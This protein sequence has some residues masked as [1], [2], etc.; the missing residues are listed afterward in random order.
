[1]AYVI[2]GREVYLL[3]AL[4]AH[5]EARRMAGEH[6]GPVFVIGAT[7]DEDNKP[8]PVVNVF[9]RVVLNRTLDQWAKGE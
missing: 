4:Q 9:E 2:V 5:V 7:L 8:V 6:D 3:G 1:M